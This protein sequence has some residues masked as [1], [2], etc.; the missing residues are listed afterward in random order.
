[1]FLLMSLSCWCFS[2]INGTPSSQC[3]RRCPCLDT[4][5]EKHRKDL[6]PTSNLFNKHQRC[7]HSPTQSV[8][9]F[10]WGRLPLVFT[11]YKMEGLQSK[12]K[13]RENLPPKRT[14]SKIQF[15][16]KVPFRW[17]ESARS[18]EGTNQCWTNPL[19]K[20][21]QKKKV[22]KK[23]VSTIIWWWQLSGMIFLIPCFWKGIRNKEKN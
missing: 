11:S 15:L 20:P 4:E 10:W 21:F 2:K 18:Q 16:Q 7:H 9:A 14:V 8:G 3:F 22:W 13:T 1:M 23:N 19:F 12:A 17:E 5:V 6:F